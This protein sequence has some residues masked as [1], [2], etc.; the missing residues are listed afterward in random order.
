MSVW[1]FELLI[2]LLKMITVISIFF[3]M[4]TTYTAIVDMAS[5]DFTM[6]CYLSFLES[7]P[8]NTS[9]EISSR[10]SSICN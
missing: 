4:A 5:A 8:Q 7:A 3:G 1:N 10:Q 9:V 6:P 2:R